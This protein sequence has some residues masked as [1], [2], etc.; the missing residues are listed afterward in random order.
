MLDPDAVKDEFKN[1]WYLQDAM[2]GSTDVNG[3]LVLTSVVEVGK[4]TDGVMER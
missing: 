2:K 4:W 1:L 3:G